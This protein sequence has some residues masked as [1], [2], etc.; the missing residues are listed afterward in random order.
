MLS[1]ASSHLF[2]EWKKVEKEKVPKRKSDARALN[3][4]VARIDGRCSVLPAV[5]R[6][7]L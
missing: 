1:L 2:L 6:R 7:N 3:L 5:A 4:A